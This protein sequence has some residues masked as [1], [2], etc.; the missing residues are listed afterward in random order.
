MLKFLCL[1]HPQ[2]VCPLGLPELIHLISKQYFQIVALPESNLDP[3]VKS[4]FQT[5]SPHCPSSPGPVNTQISSDFSV[6]SRLLN[7]GSLQF[8]SAIVVVRP[9]FTR[10]CSR[11][12]CPKQEKKSLECKLHSSKGSKDQKL[13]TKFLSDPLEVV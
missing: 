8:N 13:P 1:Q 10:S 3:Y 6:I 4:N 5:H 7:S 11:C 12:L 9:F 2:T